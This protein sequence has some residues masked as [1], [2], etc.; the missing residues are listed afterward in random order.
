[1][2]KETPQ[3]DF[4]VESEPGFRPSCE[5]IDSANSS[6]CLSRREPGGGPEGTTDR[7]M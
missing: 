7:D 4:Q 6:D 1:L 2:G 5:Q 3:R